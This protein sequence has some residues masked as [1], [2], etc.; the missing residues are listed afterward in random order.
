[1]KLKLDI[2]SK[3]T[4]MDEVFNHIQKTYKSTCKHEWDLVEQKVKGT[5]IVGKLSC[6]KC[7]AYIEYHVRKSELYIDRII[8]GSG[9]IIYKKVNL[10]NPYILFIVL[11]IV[12]VIL[13]WIKIL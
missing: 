7:K 1:M 10:I 8:H 9:Y 2:E 5:S 6:K 3:K 12:V 11:I 13:K 4:W